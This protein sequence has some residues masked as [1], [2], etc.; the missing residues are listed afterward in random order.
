MNLKTNKY[1]NDCPLTVWKYHSYLP[2]ILSII[3][4]ITS[5]TSY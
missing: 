3:G 5:L 4:I 2:F 1:F